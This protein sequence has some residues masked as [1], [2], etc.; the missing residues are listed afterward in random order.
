MIL[1]A[2]DFLMHVETNVNF[3]QCSFSFCLVAHQH[4]IGFLQ[5]LNSDDVMMAVGSTKL[6]IISVGAFRGRN[7]YWQINGSGAFWFPY[8]WL[9]KG[10]TAIIDEA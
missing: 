7:E 1:V 5:G 10:N 3:M 2:H 6:I 4:M 9:Y 8:Y